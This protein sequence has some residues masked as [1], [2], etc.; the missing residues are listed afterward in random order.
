[1]KNQVR[2]RT[3]VF[4]CLK[5]IWDSG[6]GGEV[7]AIALDAVKTRIDRFKTLSGEGADIIEAMAGQQWAQ[8]EDLICDIDSHLREEGIGSGGSRQNLGPAEG[9]RTKLVVERALKALGGRGTSRS[10]I[11]WIEQHPAELEQM[12]DA[13]LNKNVRDGKKAPVWQ[14]TVA[15]GLSLFK[16]AKRQAG[17][18]QVYML[19]DVEEEVLPLE[20]AAQAPAPKRR[21]KRPAP[22][23]GAEEAAKPAPKRQRKAKAKAA[24]SAEQPSSEVQPLET[25]AETPAVQDVPAVVSDS[26]PSAGQSKPSGARKPAVQSKPKKAITADAE[27]DRIADAFDAA[28]A[29]ALA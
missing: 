6:V 7:L 11:E 12:R 9:R 14:S 29:A 5:G 15:K 27:Q 23:S 13:R 19:P 3:V 22:E 16:K 28:F 20:D 17:Q 2:I 24:A 18:L 25:P 10:V 1:M 21:E 26:A 8:L 4:K